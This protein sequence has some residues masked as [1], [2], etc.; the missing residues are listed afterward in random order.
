MLEV[1]YGAMRENRGYGGVPSLY[2]LRWL[3]CSPSFTGKR[4]VL[5]GEEALERFILD[6]EEKAESGSLVYLPFFA[7]HAVY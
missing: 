6:R 2:G 4:Y 3:Q 1:L 7:L 5:T